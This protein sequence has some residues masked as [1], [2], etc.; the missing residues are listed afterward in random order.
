MGT[1]QALGESRMKH[2][3]LEV[4]AAVLTGL[5]FATLLFLGI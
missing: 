2:K 5:M 3:A 1:S 4:I